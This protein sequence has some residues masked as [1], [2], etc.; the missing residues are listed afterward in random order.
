MDGPIV[1]FLH[2]GVGAVVVAVVVGFL[3]VLLNAEPKATA[4]RTASK[5]TVV[6]L[7]FETFF[8]CVNGRNIKVTK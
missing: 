5:S 1:Q 7:I 3:N 8:F 2:V 4:N 6:T